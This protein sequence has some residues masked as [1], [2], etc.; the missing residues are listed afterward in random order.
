MEDDCKLISLLENFN[1]V[2][3][4]Y[5]RQVW[6]LCESVVEHSGSFVA[7]GFGDE[8]KVIRPHRLQRTHDVGGDPAAD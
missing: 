8:W 1:P 3:L 7:G 2:L 4:L 5:V 6:I